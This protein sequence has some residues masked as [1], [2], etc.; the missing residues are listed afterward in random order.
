VANARAFPG[1]TG[2][3]FDEVT[4]WRS[5]CRWLTCTLRSDQ[6]YIAGP[7][8]RRREQQ[9][10]FAPRGENPAIATIQDA[11]QTIAVDAIAHQTQA[12]QTL[13]E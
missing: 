1:A 9:A 2:L 6:R 5:P 4:A 11:P 13:T 7:D 12:R 3:G 10:R 8:A